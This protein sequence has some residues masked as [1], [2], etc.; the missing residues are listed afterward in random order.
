MTNTILF[1]LWT[2]LPR[3]QNPI[4]APALPQ[5]NQAP[6]QTQTQPATVPT[7][8]VDQLGPGDSVHVTVWTGNDYLN[9]TLTIAPDGSMFVPFYV[10]KLVLAEGKTNSQIRTM[11]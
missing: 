10:N 4:P 2:L 3:F 7:T 1:L 5:A 11:L 9:E 6:A 8:Q